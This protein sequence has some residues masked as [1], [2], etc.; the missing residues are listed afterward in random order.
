[1]ADNNNTLDMANNKGRSIREYALFDPTLH[2]IIVKP[3]VAIAQFEFK[4]I[5]F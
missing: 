3:E 5:M 2:I 1:M 4:S